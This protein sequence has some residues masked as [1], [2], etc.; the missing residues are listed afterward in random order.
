MSG[1]QPAWWPG[2]DEQLL[3]ELR[4]VVAS[5]DPVPDEVRQFARAAFTMRALDA[6][7]A[8]LLADSAA[9]SAAGTALSR[10]RSAGPVRLLSFGSADGDPE[11]ELQ[12]ERAGSSRH[13]VGQLLG[14]SA[15]SVTVE[16]EVG[17][18]DVALDDAGVFTVRG[19]RGGR[20]RLLWAT[21]AGRRMATSWVLL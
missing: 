1:S 12:V 6:E 14:A 20:I 19:L 8:E 15:G 5:A 7:L 4:R 16:T 18:T 9:D 21:A 17:R 13:L 11:L 3:A 2:D 10:T